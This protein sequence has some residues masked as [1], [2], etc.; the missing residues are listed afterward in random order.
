MRYLAKRSAY[1]VQS[2][3]KVSFIPSR[4]GT[5]KLSDRITDNSTPTNASHS[6]RPIILATVEEGPDPGDRN[7][8]QEVVG[9]YKEKFVDESSTEKPVLESEGFL[10]FYCHSRV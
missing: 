9:G 4:Y 2:P 3:T 6:V 5:F 7:P 1:C 8:A 10:K